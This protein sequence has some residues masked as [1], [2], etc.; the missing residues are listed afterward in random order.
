[1]LLAQ[2]EMARAEEEEEKKKNAKKSL[3]LLIYIDRK[4][5]EQ[6]MKGGGGGGG[7]KETEIT[8]KD[9]RK[10]IRREFDIRRMK[11]WD[12]R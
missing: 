10:M 8:E 1:M 4:K 5:R 9:K 2:K 12:P 7:L 6:S 11:S 3:S